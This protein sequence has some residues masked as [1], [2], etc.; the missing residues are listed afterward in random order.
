VVTGASSG[1]GHATATR[2]AAE[3]FRVVAAARRVDRLSSL[4]ESIDGVAVGCDVT[5]QS[6]VDNLVARVADLGGDLRLL[7][8]NAGGAFGL[9]PVANADIDD[10]RL[11]YDV[12]VLGTVRVTRG[13]LPRL[14][15]SRAGTIVVVS[16]TAG[17][18][19]YEGG[20]GYTAAKHAETAVA[21]TLRLEL[22]GEPVRVVEVDPGMVK[23]EEFSTVRFKGDAEAAAKTYAG[24]AEPLVAE[25]IADCIAFAA[26]RAQHV[27]VDRLVV[28]P[29]AQASN[30]KVHRQF[31]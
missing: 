10:W 20:G 15:A 4:C 22:N 24:V 14:V 6:D 5:E 12:N 2:L 27:N 11:M 26:T 30:Y 31:D 3:G 17:L 8:N 1:S 21:Q 25:D 28:R 9:D 19:V 16:S 7:V 13:L 29:I 18:G 23:T